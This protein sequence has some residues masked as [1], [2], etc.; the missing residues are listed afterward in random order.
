MENNSLIVPDDNTVGIDTLN[1]IQ[2]EKRNT[3]LTNLITGKTPKSVI[4]QKPQGGGSVAD[5]V[6]GWWF[7]EQLNSLF[8]YYWD[9]EIVD[10]FIGQDQIW[11]KGKLTVKSP[12]SDITVTK[13]AFGGSKIKSKA[14]PAIDIGDD[15]KSAATDALK[16][17]ATLLGIAAD[18]YGQREVLSSTAP[19]KTQLD[20]LYRIGLKKGM[21]K[22]AVAD[23]VKGKLKQPIDELE[24]A[25]ILG[26]INIIRGLPDKE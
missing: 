24:A 13:T 6:P 11:V 19:Q 5:Y 1:S 22:A 23:F 26:M 9:F 2:I 12:T 16:K 8:G 18:V 7:V 17:A 10:Q 4:F 21:D 25:A 15:L 20:S 14:N 3:A